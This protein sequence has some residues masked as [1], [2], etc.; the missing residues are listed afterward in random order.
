MNMQ[1]IHRPS[2]QRGFTLVE[3][4]VASVIGLLLLAGIIQIFLSNRSTSTLQNAVANVQENG[5]FAL[6]FLKRDIRM[7]GYMGCSNSSMV[8]PVNDLDTGATSKLSSGAIAALGTLFNGTNAFTGYTYNAGSFPPALSGILTAAQVVIGTDIIQIDSAQSCAGGNILCDNGSSSTG[9]SGSCTGV[10]S[11]EY[12]ISDNSSCQIQQNDVVLV[13]DCTHADIH[14]V[15]NT[16]GTGSTNIAH[17]ANWNN[18]PKLSVTYGNGAS[19]YKMDATYYYIGFNAN[20]DPALFRRHLVN[21]VMQ[22]EELVDGVYSMIVLYG[23]DTDGDKVP[24]RYVQAADVTQWNNVVTARV[25]LS[26]RSEQDNVT[27]TSA[28]YTYNGANVP[29]RR[30]RRDFTTTIALRNRI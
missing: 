13:S 9:T 4:M 18:T 10:P 20:N 3:M 12:K 28:N 27:S 6:G 16:P 8:T 26:V 17:G 1:T 5:R 11:A 25:T 30:L 14:G 7:A 2:A 19:V 29:D 15:S 22:S 23:E 24:N 21:G